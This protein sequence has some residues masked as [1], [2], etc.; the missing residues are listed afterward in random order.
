TPLLITDQKKG[1]G[2]MGTTVEDVP[3]FFSK[4]FV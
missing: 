4:L 1:S 2:R 3:P